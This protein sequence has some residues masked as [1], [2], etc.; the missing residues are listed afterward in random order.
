[1]LHT[2]KSTHA[3]IFTYSN[4]NKNSGSKLLSNIIIDFLQQ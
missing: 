1:M 3:Q 2:P 4:F